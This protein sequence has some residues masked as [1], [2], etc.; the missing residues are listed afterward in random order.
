MIVAVRKLPL[1]P[2]TGT[3]IRPQPVT[4]PQV[5]ACSRT[6]LVAAG[7]AP[8]AAAPAAPV[9]LVV[10][11]HNL[12]GWGNLCQFIT[13]ARRA[14][15]KGQYQVGWQGTANQALW[16][17]LTHCEIL[18]LFPDAMNMEATY[19]VSTGARGLFCS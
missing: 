2:A 15:P 10:L 3:L 19:A 4:V 9:R 12:Q 18:L 1:A 11:P 5:S 6:P 17:Q 8:E 14:A 13:V 7:R 16:A